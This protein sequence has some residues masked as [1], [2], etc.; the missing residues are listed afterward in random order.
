MTPQ[1]SLRRVV[2]L[3]TCDFCGETGLPAVART[4]YGHFYIVP[5]YNCDTYNCPNERGGPGGWTLAL[6]R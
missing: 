3:M 4:E 5:Q 6:K 2:Y 1:Q